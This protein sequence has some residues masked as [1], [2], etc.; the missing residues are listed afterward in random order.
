M[1]EGGNGSMKLPVASYGVFGE[2]EYIES[3]LL[4]NYRATRKT[5]SMVVSPMNAFASPS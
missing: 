5:S 2:G 4:E 1:N 3:V